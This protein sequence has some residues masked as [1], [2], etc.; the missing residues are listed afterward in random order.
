MFWV[1]GFYFDTRKTPD[2][3]AKK[4]VENMQEQL[5]LPNHEGIGL[6]DLLIPNDII[7]SS[8]QK[9]PQERVV[10]RSSFT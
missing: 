4:S 9:V 7:R 6:S 5:F 1:N 2:L 8:R 3:K 10:E